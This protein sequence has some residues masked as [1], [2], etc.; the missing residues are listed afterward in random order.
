MNNLIAIGQVTDEEKAAF[1]RKALPVLALGF[2]VLWL[3]AWGAYKLATS[4]ERAY[5][6]RQR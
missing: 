1:R 2:G 6:R 5:A 3:T 4:E